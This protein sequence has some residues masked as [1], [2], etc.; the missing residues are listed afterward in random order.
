LPSCVAIGVRSAGDHTPIPANC[1]RRRPPDPPSPL[2]GRS[3]HFS[4]LNMSSRPLPDRARN[5]PVIPILTA[6]SLLLLSR[7]QTS[8]ALSPAP[9]GC[10]PRAKWGS[11]LMQGPQASSRW[12]LLYELSSEPWTPACV[13]QSPLLF[14][15]AFTNLTLSRSR[16]SLDVRRL[17]LWAEFAESARMSFRTLCR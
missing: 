13:G 9:R 8:L 1:G 16:K 5:A 15:T 14:F 11:E 10:A 3:L 7:S 6:T 12:C 17:C 2:E 4:H